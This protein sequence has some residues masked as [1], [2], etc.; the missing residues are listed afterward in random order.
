[1]TEKNGRYQPDFFDPERVEEV[2]RVPYQE[3]AGQARQY[4]REWEISPA[5]D[6][7]QKTELVLIDV[8]NTF[9]TPGYELFVA[10][11]SGRGAVE[12]NQRLVAW[13]YR[14]LAHI[15]AITATMDTHHPLQI[16]HALFLVDEQG[17]HP[18]PNTQISEKEIQEGVWKVNPHASRFLGYDPAE[19]NDHL[20]Y[21]ARK[22]SEMEKYQ[23]QIWPY[24][25][26]LGGVG[27]A[28]VSAVEEAVFFH[29]ASRHARPDIRIKGNHPLTEAY[30]AI[31]PEVF[32]G[33]SGE[34]VAGKSPFL[35]NKLKEVDRMV[36]AGQA[37]SHC[38]AWTVSD[39]LEQI[40]ADDPSL[41][42]KVFLL[43]DCTS[44]VVIPEVVDFS[45]R[46]E[47]AF[48]R[49]EA[50]GMHRVT[51]GSYPG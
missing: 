3:R 38:V 5:A 31:G 11:K 18:D 30:S 50:A 37:K 14:N 19:L 25:A 16:F 13:I 17:N 46:A 20:L 2:Y 43:E 1:M 7:Q 36:I 35:I 28:L 26:M 34:K 48:D 10:G 8:Q 51:T 6:D 41:A 15:S 21:Y 27:H 24:H 4:A 47:Q 23:L 39:L 33:P 49:F 22:L 12:D 44:P 42:D 9:C 32:E 45:Q 29:S 40:E